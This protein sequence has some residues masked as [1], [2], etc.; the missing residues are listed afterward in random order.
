MPTT[1]SV[2]SARSSQ[3]E[4][5]TV[6]VTSI[7]PARARFIGI[8]RRIGCSPVGLLRTSPSL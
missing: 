1:F 8:F 7:A 4:R 6:S 2:N 3:S 5:G